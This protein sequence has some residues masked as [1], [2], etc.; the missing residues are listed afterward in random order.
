[1]STVDASVRRVGRPRDE[2]AEKAIIDA[3][4]ALVGEVGFGN[5]TVDAVAARAG[6]GKATIYRRWT[7]K[8]ELL[9]S[10]LSC[11]SHEVDAPDTG[12]LA[13]DLAG[14][15][16]NIADHVRTSEAGRAMPSL[17]AEAEC[18][19]DLRAV[20]H[21]FV[22][23]RRAVTRALL[24]RA[25][26]RGEVRDDIDVELAIDMFSGPIFYRR[27]LSGAP[28]RRSDGERAVELLLNGI[29]E[30]PQSRRRSRE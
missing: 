30:K 19:P 21:R 14:L 17:V 10:A 22:D 23:S 12:S 24:H 11:L 8:E 15:W 3:T 9:L 2:N 28:I 26:A 25:Q 16:G 4:V 29:G 13:G 27:L 6:V 5:L 7:S 1:L 20:L 18:N